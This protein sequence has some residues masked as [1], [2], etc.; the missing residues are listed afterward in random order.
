MPT[1][2][3]MDEFIRL[4]LAR[5]AAQQRL[6]G[7]TE[8]PPPQ[9]GTQAV[10][11]LKG[12]LGGLEAE[13]KAQRDAYLRNMLRARQRDATQGIIAAGGAAAMRFSGKD[14]SPYAKQMASS[15]NEDRV[16]ADQKAFGD[17]LGGRQKR[18][19]TIGD[20]SIKAG[21]IDAQ[22]YNARLD[23]LQ[24]AAQNATG[25][26][27][28]AIQAQID[29]LKQCETERHNL[30]TEAIGWGNVNKPSG[31][32]GAREEAREF[33]FNDDLAKAQVNYGGL[34]P[35][36]TVGADG[37]PHVGPSTE[38]VKKVSSAI[39]DL[40]SVEDAGK[41]MMTILS[42]NR[43][44]SALPGSEDEQIRSV[45]QTMI[46]MKAKGEGMFGLGVLTGIDWDL[47]SKAIGKSGIN[48]DYLSSQGG[49]KRIATFLDQVRSQVMSR[50][51]TRRYELDDGKPQ[52]LGEWAP[53]GGEAPQQ[54]APTPGASLDAKKKRAEQLKKELGL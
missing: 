13:E 23:A 19:E 24:M 30:A 7:A 42:T 36:V 6:Q 11:E 49:A 25:A 48:W 5:E 47:V 4:R 8:A 39:E 26:E 32:G 21:G 15:E 22:T 14:T 40:R 27:K 43:W 53:A 35:K 1:Q 37:K 31:L 46:G 52:S 50:A 12:S 20:A 38:D 10:N 33:K 41:K 45:L 44:K 29:Q 51:L 9:M 2:Q 16:R 3:E 17:W 28:A 54:A 18:A 34:R